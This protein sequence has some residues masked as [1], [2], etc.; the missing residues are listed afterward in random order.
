MEVVD[1][2]R[3][4]SHVLEAL[5][6]A[7]LVDEGLLRRGVGDR[8]DFALWELLCQEE[9]DGSPSAAEIHDL[10]R[11]VGE[12]DEREKITA[13]AH[14]TLSPRTFMP[15]WIPALSTYCWSIVISFTVYGDPEKERERETR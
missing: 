2:A 7:S 3:D 10:Y 4:D 15:S 13:A 14:G 1:V 9:R 8:S 5:L 12:K 11:R 6:L